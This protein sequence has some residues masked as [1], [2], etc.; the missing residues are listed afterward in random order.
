MLNYDTTEEISPVDIAGEQLLKRIYM[1]DPFEGG[2]DLEATGPKGCG[3]TSLIFDI[4]SH[5]MKYNP[6][7]LVFMRDRYD[8]PIQFNR[9]ENWRIFAEGDITLRFRN[10][11][12]NTF[13]NIPVTTF[14]NY[15]ELYEQAQP[16]IINVVYLKDEYSWIRKDGLIDF[17]RRHSHRTGNKYLDQSKKTPV[18][19]T[20]IFTEYED[21]CPINESK[22]IWSYCKE[23][24]GI[25]KET[26]KGLTS[27][28]F[29]TQNSWDCDHRVRGKITMKA[30][31]K[32]AKVDN[33]SP[34]EQGA[35][36]SLGQYDG[37]RQALISWAQSYGKIRFKAFRP[38]DLLFEVIREY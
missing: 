7:E 33:I 8:S 5:I 3:K 9:F 13:F 25:L 30:Y 31:L 26:R 19:K 14:N 6:E 29:D 17:I 10:I 22:P 36:N 12:N 28:F 38:K 1:R 23:F 16:R 32:G 18:W 35:V 37:E 27:S 20:I 34:I 15:E 4:V 21:V 11:T 2:M 24:T